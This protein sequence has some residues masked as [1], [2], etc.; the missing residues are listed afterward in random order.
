M[1]NLAPGS[2]VG[3][4]AINAKD[5]V[6][7]PRKVRPGYGAIFF[8]GQTVRDI[9]WIT[10]TVTDNT[11]R[12]TTVARQVNVGAPGA[13]AVASERKTVRLPQRSWT[14]AAPAR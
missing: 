4:P 8:N 6:A 14:A 13:G 9:G 5:Q 3:A 11:G 1:I 12:S 2:L 10:L 7:M